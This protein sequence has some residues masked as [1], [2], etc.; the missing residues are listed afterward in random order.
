MTFLLGLRHMPIFMW[1]AEYCIAIGN[2][3]AAKNHQAFPPFDA[4]GSIH[5]RER[6]G[7]L[8]RHP[9]RRWH[10]GHPWDDPEGDLYDAISHPYRRADVSR[11][12]YHY[13]TAGF[14]SLS[15]YS[16]RSGGLRVTGV[17]GHEDL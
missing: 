4:R 13:S 12:D 11:I 10:Q 9:S 14:G 16:F 6:R 7:R 2:P 15:P 3:H 1:R 17:P 8:P 5:D